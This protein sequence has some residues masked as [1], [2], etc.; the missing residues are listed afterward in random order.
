M[1]SSLHAFVF[2]VQ[3]SVKDVF[4][5]NIIIDNNLK[6]T[7]K[8][9]YSYPDI[10][11]LNLEI[12]LE[13]CGTG[14]CLYSDVKR[15]KW[16]KQILNY[17]VENL[18][19]KKIYSYDFRVIKNI[20]VNEQDINKIKGNKYYNHYDEERRH[21]TV[22]KTLSV[23]NINEGNKHNYLYLTVKDIED[24]EIETVEIRRDL[25]PNIEINKTYNFAFT[26]YGYDLDDDIY[27]LFKKCHLLNIT[28]V[29]PTFN[30]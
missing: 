20:Y 5:D 25:V 18:K 15:F 2:P 26:Y 8:I 24:N 7:I 28:D 23:L 4:Y 29:N 16:N 17:L 1:F 12:E 21:H 3:S 27:E 11:D 22:T 19:D 6:D 10:N 14:Y 30:E 9:E 13:D